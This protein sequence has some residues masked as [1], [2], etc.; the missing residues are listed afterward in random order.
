M[1][2]LARIVYWLACRLAKYVRLVRPILLAFGSWEKS[3]TQPR[4]ELVAEYLARETYPVIVDG[5]LAPYLL[6]HAR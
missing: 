3:D 5:D 1:N 4:S 6:H 2:L